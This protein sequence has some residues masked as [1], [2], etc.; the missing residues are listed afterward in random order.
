MS[1]LP[2][3]LLPPRSPETHKGDVGHVLVVAGSPGLSGAAALCSMGALRAG[4]GLVTLGI[5]AGLQDVMAAKLAEVMTRP[6]PETKVRTLSLQALPELVSLIE[7]MNAVAIGPGLSQESQTKQLVRQLLPRV[8]KPCVV[9]ADGL[10]ALADEPQALKRLT[11]PLILTPH[12]GEMARLIRQSAADVQRDRERTAKSFA[13][14]YRAVVVLKGHRTVV[15]NVDGELYVNDTG[16]PGMASGGMGDVLTGVI[17]G[18]LGQKLSLFDAA[19]L[20]VYLHGLAGD[21]AAA[22]CGQVG[23]IASDLLARIPLAIRQYQ[24]GR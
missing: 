15:A 7:T 3:G 16:N 20:G 8:T 18:L 5:P 17:A 9:D 2:A 24:Q 19:R 14:Q 22:E 10:N 23:L 4:A 11:T 13:E 1:R 21:L 6:L 12:P